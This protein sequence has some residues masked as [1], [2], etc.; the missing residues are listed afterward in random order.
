MTCYRLKGF[1][2]A[3][4]EALAG[5]IADITEWDDDE[6]KIKVTYP[7]AK[8]TGI[9]GRIGPYLH[10]G[11]GGAEMTGARPGA[12]L[13]SRPPEPAWNIAFTWICEVTN[14]RVCPAP[15]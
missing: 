13:G 6:L 11:T 1:T 10:A 8:I 3:D 15:C 14:V 5:K 7:A 9:I 4:A 12:D 2:M